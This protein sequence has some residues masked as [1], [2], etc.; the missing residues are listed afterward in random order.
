VTAEARGRE[1]ATD[2]EIVAYALVH[3]HPALAE[4]LA[5][6]LPM[7]TAFAKAVRRSWQA[8]V[9]EARGHGGGTPSDD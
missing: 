8:R 7:P 3:Y 1:P 6:V 4:A 2:G 5:G 9:A